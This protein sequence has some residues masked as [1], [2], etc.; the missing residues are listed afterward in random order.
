MSLG[1]KAR[2]A[3]IRMATTKTMRAM[4]SLTLSE[5]EIT[6]IA[7]TKGNHFK[8]NSKFSRKQSHY[9]KSMIQGGKAGGYSKGH[10][11]FDNDGRANGQALNSN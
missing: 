5:R 7:Y 6:A 2:M 3:T 9:D 1:L 11:I 10:H 4:K 8:L